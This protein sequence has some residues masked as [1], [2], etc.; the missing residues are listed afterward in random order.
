[1]EIF[2]YII[3]FWAAAFGIALP[4][5]AVILAKLGGSKLSVWQI[6]KKL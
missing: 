4:A 6:L 2:C 3:A 1:M 5:G